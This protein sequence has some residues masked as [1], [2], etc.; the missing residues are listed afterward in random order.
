MTDF[1][2]IKSS[3]DL[4]HVVGQ[5]IKLDARGMGQCPFHDDKSP[6]FS[7]RRQ[8]FKCF[9]CDAHGDVFDFIMRLDRVTLVEAMQSL[10]TPGPALPPRVMPETDPD[11]MRAVWRFCVERGVSPASTSWGRSR[12]FQCTLPVPCVEAPWPTEK[13]HTG[14]R[15]AF[16]VRDWVQWQ[17]QRAGVLLAPLY[18]PQETEPGALALRFTHEGADPKVLAVKGCR[19]TLRAYGGPFDWTRHV[20]VVEGLPDTL[21]AQEAWPQR[22]VVGV[23]SATCL[24][25]WAD[26]LRGVERVTVVPQLD[27]CRCAVPCANLWECKSSASGKAVA[28]LVAAVPHVRVFDWAACARPGCKD[29]ADHWKAKKVDARTHGA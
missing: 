22:T 1:D 26:V 24:P 28:E 16:S 6:S 4:A 5:R 18:G 2:A 25:R 11:A 20:M 3:I 23:F 13:V 10:G 19:T 29:F 8:T 27:A 12:G 9:G 15:G 21:A 17:R 7:V 14:K